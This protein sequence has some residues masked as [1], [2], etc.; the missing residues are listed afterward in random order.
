MNK[1][2]ARWASRLLI[3]LLVTCMAIPTAVAEGVTETV[4]ETS[5]TS[6]TLDQSGTVTVSIGDTL[7]LNATLAPEGAQSTLKWTSSKKKVASV[8]NGVVTP[9]KV[10]TTTITVKT[11]NKKK[12]KVKVKVIDSTKPSKVVLDKTGTQ[13]ILMGEHLQLTATLYPETAKSGLKW[14]S[15]K[16]RVAVVDQNGM[17]GA[18]STGTTTITVTTRNKKKAKVK[19]KVIDNGNV[20][21]WTPDDYNLPYLVYVCKKTHTI[22]ILAKDANGEWTRVLR[23][24]ST[25]LGRKNVT[26]VGY[27]SIVK[28]E[29]WHK[30]GSGYS[31]F[32]SK[33]NIG[34]Y[35]HG[36]IYKQ[37]NQHTIRPSYY[38]CIGKDCS[39]GCIRT[40]CGAAAWVYYN[41]PLGTLV[42]VAPNGR[43]STPRPKKISKKATKDPSDPGDHPEIL[44]TGFTLEP[45]VLNLEKGATQAVTPATINPSNTSTTG[46]TYHSSNTAVATVAANGVV[47]AVGAGTAVIQAIANDDYKCSAVAT[48]NVTDSSATPKTAEAALAEAAVVEVPDEVVAQDGALSSEESALTIAEEDAV[49]EVPS[50][51]GD[52]AVGAEQPAGEE[53]VADAAAESAEDAPADVPDADTEDAAAD[54]EEDPAASTEQ[55]PTLTA[56]ED[57]LSLAAE[58]VPEDVSEITVD[59]E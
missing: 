34:I 51:A 13:T 14:K 8:K 41:C 44:I 36:P 59:Q 20:P 22:A 12:A 2:I 35:L 10:G 55:A 40:T 7:T 27:F 43:F 53:A 50:P 46:F 17:V 1:T 58:E 4:A 3:L 19:V 54:A 6:V 38:N 23:L 56:E 11:A 57:G 48:V 37:K 52:E 47:T 26:D 21:I 24:F 25:G 39:S 18:I 16:K 49:D 33:L 42:F 28:K 45:A 32:A 31:P 5:P 9:K 29:R 15:S 30:W